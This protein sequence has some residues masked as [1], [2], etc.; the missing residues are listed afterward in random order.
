MYRFAL[1]SLLARPRRAA[2]T[3][4]AVLV[5][6]ALICG[7]Y[8]FTDTVRA[9]LHDLFSTQARGSRVVV[10][11]PQ[12]LYSATNPPAS[13]PAS[14]E[15]RV[16]KL[17]GVSSVTGGI[18][19]VATIIGADGRPIK[20]AGSPTFAL[21]YPAS[22]LR[23]LRGG[24]PGGP[25]QVAIDQSTARRE[26]YD[27]GD[28]VAVITGQPA[29]RFRVSG[30][31]RL[32]NASIG[33]AT[34]AVFDL[35][36]AQSLYDKQGMLDVLYVAGAST[37]TL[38]RE[39]APLLPPGVAV[40]STSQQIDANVA[41]IED[42]LS[43]LTSGLRAF[44]YIAMLI[45]A[46]VIVGTFAI[47][48]AQRARELALLRALGATRRQVLGLVIAEAA[49]I[50]VLPTVGGLGAGLGAA[51]AIRAVFRAVGVDVPSTHLVLEPRTIAISLAV[52]IGVTI[53]AGVVPAIRA[54]RVPPIEALQTSS[55]SQARGSRLG[56][57]P[58]LVLAFIGAG[59]AFTS[60]SSG[61]SQL[62]AVAV[63]AV[64][65]VLS[66]AL[67]I[68][69]AIPY[70]ARGAAWPLERRGRITATLAR[71]NATRNPGRT[72]ITASSLMIGLA[73][74]LFV[75]VYIGGVRTATRRAVARTFAADFAIQS[76]DGSSSIPAVSAQA[77]TSVQNLLAVSAIRSAAVDVPGVGQVN[78]AG[79]DPSSIA[80]VY[81]F[82]WAASPA[83]DPGALGPGDVL[84]E[85]ATARAAHLRIGSHLRLASPDGLSTIVTVRGIYS[86]RAL[87]R[88]LALPL[89][90][91]DQLTDQSRLQEVLI[92]LGPDSDA[93]AAAAQLRQALSGL[94][95]VVVRSER[96]LAAQAS[97]RVNTVLVLFYALLAMSA[98]M[99]LIGMLN[100][101]MLSVHERTRELGLLRALGMTRAQARAVIRDESLITAA[102]G[103]L[104]GAALGL[105]LGWLM[106]RALAIP[107]A[108][109]GWQLALMIAVG[110]LVGAL[111][112]WRP[113]ARVARL[114]V[115]TALAYE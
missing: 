14:L 95:G 12:G 26:H 51:L 49:V 25:G 55:G 1:R 44:G 34:F 105:G 66:A 76:S 82:D 57:G 21:S 19:D 30:I 97:S 46:L 114:D 115:L 35:K 103:T 112:A 41:Q 92:K 73:L 39:I 96:E 28:Q 61:G 70:L 29:R 109:P 23:F 11:S 79:I 104:V 16:A 42:R 88:G 74:V 40:R 90:T 94:P 54:T 65:L 18:A 67:L 69:P 107:F 58:A 53:A 101:L 17:P 77:A 71:E 4:L 81:R 33:S 62:A 84:L 22:G 15:Q 20:P 9:A 108:L 43:V 38:V 36:T 78:A 72:A 2:L 110:L 75:S 27:V 85:R 87:L 99:A 111:A 6:V 13:F 56:I 106:T 63:G 59:V 113:A 91:F 86:D 48:V 64:L 89:Q 102:T 7:A 31:A 5:G 52:G 98:A 8:V 10:S 37:S 45:G 83:P 93:A 32:G 24:P 47:T 3:A 50:G 68:P 80:Q 60:G 100:A